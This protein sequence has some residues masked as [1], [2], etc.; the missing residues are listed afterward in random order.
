MSLKKQYITVTQLLNFIKKILTD[1]IPTVNF[2]G[3]ISSLKTS[4]NGH[5]YLDI[6]DESSTASCVI[7]ASRFSR[8]NF[9]P[10]A[11]MKV[12]C[13][14]TPDVYPQRGSLQIQILNMIP[15]GEGDLMLKFI[16][17][18]EKL[19]GEGL[20]DVSRK[21]PIPFLPKTIGIITSQEGSVISDMKVKL[22]ERM[23]SVKVLLYPSAVQGKGACLQLVKGIEYFNSKQNVDVIIIARG[24]GSLEDL[25]EFK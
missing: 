19:A 25:L 2:E 1:S 16:E 13:Q 7:W 6:K 22:E 12:L 24:G 14:G 9:K 21:R 10:K 5:C 15:A 18:R 20:F 4:I 8:L 17:L 23:P 3:E 11:G